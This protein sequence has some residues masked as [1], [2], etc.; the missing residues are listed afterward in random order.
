MKNVKLYTIKWQF[1]FLTS[2]EISKLTTGSVTQGMIRC[3]Y[4]FTRYAAKCGSFFLF[5]DGKEGAVLNLF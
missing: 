3:K 4:E 1:L 5:G 2:F